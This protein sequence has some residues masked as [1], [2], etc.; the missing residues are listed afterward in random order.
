VGCLILNRGSCSR[1]DSA[2]HWVGL[3][4]GRSSSEPFIRL[5]SGLSFVRGAQTFARV[6]RNGI[7]QS[8]VKCSKRLGLSFGSA[9]VPLLSRASHRFFKEFEG[10]NRGVDSL[11]VY[12]CDGR[13]GLF[14]GLLGC[15]YSS[16]VVAIG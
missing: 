1:E 15:L 4:F 6:S 12:L 10:S 14:L 9:N 3:I 16:I 11:S 5:S 13:I 2:S 8:C 7:V